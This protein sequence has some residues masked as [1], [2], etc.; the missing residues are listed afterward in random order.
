[1]QAEIC[2]NCGERIAQYDLS[3]KT[4]QT[5]DAD[6]SITRGTEHREAWCG[7]CVDSEF[8]HGNVTAEIVKKSTGWRSDLGYYHA[9][10]SYQFLGELK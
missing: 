5:S 4:R 8:P 6:D 3:V 1:M 10:S 2:D 7:H 9:S